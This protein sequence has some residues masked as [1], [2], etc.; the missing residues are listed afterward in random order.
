MKILSV[1]LLFLLPFVGFSQNTG[2]ETTQQP[3]P[4]KYYPTMPAD[5]TFTVI[6]NTTGSAVPDEVLLD[7]NLYRM[8]VDYFWR[9]DGKIEILI[10]GTD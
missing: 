5:S 7:I 3:A 4:L 10:H 8:K 6:K 9:V 2:Q 1:L